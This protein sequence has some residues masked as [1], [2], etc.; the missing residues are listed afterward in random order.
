MD[1]LTHLRDS[2]ADPLIKEGVDGVP[3]TFHIMQHYCLLREDIDSVMELSL[4]PDHKDPMSSVSSKVRC[5][6]VAP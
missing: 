2:I 1:Y 5:L 6:T 3:A 4:W